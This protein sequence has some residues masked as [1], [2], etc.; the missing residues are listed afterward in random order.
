MIIQLVT[1]M[2][3]YPLEIASLQSENSEA[4]WFT[5]GFALEIALG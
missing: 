5:D 4:A 1:E 3:P 2:P